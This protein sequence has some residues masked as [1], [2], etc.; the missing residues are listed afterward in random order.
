M[1]R[2]KKI[3]F[4]VQRY[5]KEV[6]GGAEFYC[7]K[8][9]ERLNRGYNVE[10]LTTCALDYI[11]W[12]NEY[13]EGMESIEGI[14]VRRFK[15]KK[16]RNQKKFQRISNEVFSDKK[17][18][19]KKEIK[20]MKKQGPFCPG[21]INYIRKNRD[22]YDLFIFITYLYYTTFFGLREVADKSILIPAAHD[23]PPLYLDIFKQVFHLPAAII[24]LTVEEKK[25]IYKIFNNSYIDSVVTGLGINPPEN[26]NPDKF[27]EKFA[28]SD[29]F[30]LY[31]GRIDVSKGCRELLTYFIKYKKEVNTDL[32]LVLMGKANMEI[33]EHK[34][35]ISTG[36]V[37]EMD[38]FNGISAAKLLILPSPYESLSISVLESLSLGIPVL[39]NGR[40]EV[41]KA[42]CLRSNAGLYYTDY[43]EFEGCLE[44][45]LKHHK[46]RIIM[47][48][49]GEEYIARNY[50]WDIV[51]EKFQKL[52]Q[53][54]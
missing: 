20:W 43:H 47:G 5:G 38:K 9:A 6:N 7:R 42:H 36:F 51:E 11:S 37:S 16:S 21:L 17:H 30:V 48:K 50:R 34:D 46:Q 22:N 33:P 44:Y 13:T 29:D 24:Y 32:K 4:V 25:L 1:K 49:N 52:I 27:R 18:D 15:V 39:V 53:E 14:T 23:E 54:I 45:M 19:Y 3:A 35:I 10:I 26:V 2:D 28:V 12:D 8:I 40:C 31:L 41:L